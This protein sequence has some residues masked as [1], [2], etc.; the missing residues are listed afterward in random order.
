M[1][2]KRNVL[3]SGA[4]A[5]IIAIALIATAIF[6]PGAGILS[7]SATTTLSSSQTGTL[8]VQLTD[9]PTVPPGVTNVYISYS[10]MAVHVSDASNYSGWYQVAPAG[11]I[12]L[13][14]VL[15][16][17]ITLGSAPVKAGEFNAIGFNITSATVTV[18]GKNQSAFI[19]S[20]KLFVPLVGGVQVTSGASIG[21]LVDLSPTVIA[22]TNGSQTAYVLIP[23]AHTLRIPDS[24]W[25]QSEH[26]GDEVKDISQQ[27]WFEDG[28]RGDISL[29]NLALT[30]DSL[31]VT[32]TNNGANSTVISSLTVAYPLDIIC[33]QY[34]GA[35]MTNTMENDLPHAIP[36]AQFGILSNG[37]LL[38]YNFTAAAVCHYTSSDGQQLSSGSPSSSTD[39]DHSISSSTTTT[40]MSTSNPDQSTSTS[41][42]TS[43]ISTGSASSSEEDA[44]SATQ[45]GECQI[46]PNVDQ[47]EAQGISYGYVLAAG[48]SVT[49]TFSGKIATISP[50]ILNYIHLTVSVP[51]SLVDALSNIQTGQLYMMGVTGPFDTVATQQVTAS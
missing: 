48:Q 47:L 36:V 32:V 12:D 14:S 7:K 51:T 49:F 24:T 11:E 35:C 45:T 5:G 43:T 34:S 33:Q 37:N 19:S 25:R 9:P 40:S 4:I 17:S 13:M 27:P 22:V 38:Q 6:V 46:G 20:N 23:S 18:N 2:S 26:Q 1:S 41:T 44:V 29:S 10:E 31:S 15:N 21:V 3:L 50:D 28:A 30:N 39:A 8:G 16:T 42:T